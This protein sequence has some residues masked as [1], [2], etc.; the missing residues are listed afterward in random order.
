MARNTHLQDKNMLS[1][2]ILID[3]AEAYVQSNKNPSG[4][5]TLNWIVGSIVREIRIVR[6]DYDYDTDNIRYNY[7]L[8]Q[9]SILSTD[10]FNYGVTDPNYR[11]LN[12]EAISI[13]RHQSMTRAPEG[14][15]RAPSPLSPITSV[16]LFPMNGAWGH[17]FKELA[18]ESLIDWTTIE[19]RQPFF[20]NITVTDQTA[21]DGDDGTISF[22][23]SWGGDDNLEFSIDNGSTWQTDKLFVNQ[24]DGS[25]NCLIKDGLGNISTLRVVSIA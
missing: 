5:V 9:E 8:K 3:G 1:K 21:E 10:S 16:S 12:T 17:H 7:I 20:S 18:Q 24:A 22:D 15:L 11:Y 2:K 4:E 13:T 14:S 25:Y 23:D 19:Y 6:T